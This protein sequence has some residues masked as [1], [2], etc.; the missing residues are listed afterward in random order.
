MPTRIA[1]SLSLLSFAACL[2]AGG[3]GGGASFDAVVS[4]ALYALAFTF[5]LGLILGTMAQKMLDESLLAEATKLEEARAAKLEEYQQREPVLTV[6][7]GE[8]SVHPSA[9][10]RAARR[11]A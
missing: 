1:G 6:G 3:F 9:E 7:S 10:R 5:V 4:R 2:L 8:P 11:A